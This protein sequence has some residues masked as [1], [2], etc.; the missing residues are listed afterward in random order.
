MLE[1][2]C[3]DHIINSMLKGREK[4][5]K[6]IT[7]WKLQQIFETYIKG[8]MTLTELNNT[9]SECKNIN[10]LTAIQ[11]WNCKLE[12]RYTMNAQNKDRKL[13]HGG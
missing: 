9:T 6:I 8:S 11:G 7:I 5:N 10:H 3:Y 4:M 1:L 12:D 13:K 2:G